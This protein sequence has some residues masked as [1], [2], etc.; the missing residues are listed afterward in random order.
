M[1]ADRGLKPNRMHSLFYVTNSQHSED[2]TPVRCNRQ[3]LTRLVRYFEDVVVENKLSALVIEGRCLDGD[4]AREGERL[5]TLAGVARHLY[6]F[7]CDKS[8]AS[9]SWRIGRGLNLTHLEENDF[10]GIETGPFV[11][12]M[13]PR[14]CGMLV[15]YALPQSSD[16]SP[17][18]FEMMWTFDP[19]AVFTAME[20]LMARITAHSK[21]ERQRLETLVRITT[22]H[23]TSLRLGLS[24]TTKLAM[25]MQRQN[26]R[27]TAINS[28]SSAISSTLE[29]EKIL[30]S[31]VQEV[32][33]SLRARR[34]ALVLWQE[35]TSMPESMSVY[36]CEDGITDNTVAPAIKSP[37]QVYR[38]AIPGPLEM[39][40]TYRGN[41]IGVMA[42]EDDTPGRVWEDEEMLMVKTVSD[43]LAV[44]ISHARL[45][46]RVQTEAITDPLTG[47]FN[48]RHFQDQLVR[49][50]K[51]ADRANHKL[52]LVLLDLDHLKNVNDT[53]GHRAGDSCLSHVARTMQATV[54]EI[55]ICARYGGEEFVIILPR[56]GREDAINVA[57]RV[58]EAI[59]ATPVEKVG[60][61]T[62]SIGVAT[63]PD[64]ADTRETLIEMADRAMYLAKARGRNQVRALAGRVPPEPAAEDGEIAT[65]H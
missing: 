29:L 42:V 22:P 14:F 10:H 5:G 48:H 57:S 54:R 19:N 39:P 28:I 36:E 8:C 30:Q 17:A 56:C 43:Q 52:S 46:R 45:F 27:E 26:E 23:S 37:S 20:Y 50:L 61:I 64:D 21:D 18:H 47:L 35:G 1:F 11:L 34:A 13:E 41:T 7:S 62:A 15:S 65:I 4:P 49:E 55:D 3:T 2:L 51:L 58:R 6:V 25:L 63:Y 33:R 59:A 40:V 16:E 9:R 12:V 31:A 24:L 44:A 32:G 38:G 60:Q 53:L